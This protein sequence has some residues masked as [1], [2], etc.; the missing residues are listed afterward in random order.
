MYNSTLSL[1]WALDEGGRSVP[2]PG[3]FPAGKERPGTRSTVG[4]VGPSVRNISPSLGFNPRTVQPIAS[5]K[6]NSDIPHTHEGYRSILLSMI[7]KISPLNAAP[8]SVP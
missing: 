6:K 1:T 4:W 2:R 3:R 5:P 7:G 8:F